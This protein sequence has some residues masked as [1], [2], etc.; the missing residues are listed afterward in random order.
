MI[1]KIKIFFKTER[2]DVAVYNVPGIHGLRYTATAA[3]TGYL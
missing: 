3:Y 1:Q 2:G